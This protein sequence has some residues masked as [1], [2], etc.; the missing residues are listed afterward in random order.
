[1]SLLSAGSAD[2]SVSLKPGPRMRTKPFL[3]ADW[4][5]LVMLNYEVERSLLADYI[6]RGVELDFWQ[7][8]T[9]VSLVGFLFLNTRVRDFFIPFHRNFEEVN[10]RFYVRRGDHRGVVFIREIV[11]RRAVAWV[12]NIVYGENYVCLPMRHRGDANGYEYAWRH[13]GRWNRMVAAQLSPPRALLPGSHEEF[14]AEHY[15]GYARR[16][17]EAT[18]EYRVEHSPWSVQSSAAA[19]FEGSVAGLYPRDF[20]FIDALAPD[21]AFVADGSPVAVFSSERLS[22]GDSQPCTT[23]T[24]KA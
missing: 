16:S 17:A 5:R 12:A 20:A 24:S 23:T 11:P 6:P 2:R 22:L 21:S 8:R 1:V 13:L 3:T 9:Y 15:W 18:Y 7:G 14:I 19:R 10:L 4:R